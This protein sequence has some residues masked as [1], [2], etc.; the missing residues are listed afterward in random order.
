MDVKYWILCILKVWQVFLSLQFCECKSKEFPVFLLPVMNI[1]SSLIDWCLATDLNNVWLWTHLCLCHADPVLFQR[2][3]FLFILDTIWFS[4]T[5]WYSECLLAFGIP[6]GIRDTFWHLG[7]LLA[8]RIPC[9][10]RNTFLPFRVPCSNRNTCWHSGYL[11][12]IGI[13]FGF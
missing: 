6:C 3:W 7:Y 12:A 4:D 11:V 1:L 8:L 9:S 2:S 13:P 10:N 5:F